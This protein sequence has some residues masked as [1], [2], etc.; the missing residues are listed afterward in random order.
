MTQNFMQCFRP[1]NDLDSEKLQV[2]ILQSLRMQADQGQTTDRGGQVQTVT[3][4]PAGTTTWL[5]LGM[6][7][8]DGWPRRRRLSP[9]VAEL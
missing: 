9:R 7:Y 1:S 5:Q 8:L 4:D 2:G 3:A 6:S